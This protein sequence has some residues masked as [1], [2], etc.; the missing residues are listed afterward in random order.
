MTK[1]PMQLVSYYQKV[2]SSLEPDSE[3]A[4]MAHYV[5]SQA[6]LAASDYGNAETALR[7]T[8]AFYPDK[9]ILK[10][11]LGVIY[12]KSGRYD[13][14]VKLLQETNR[15]ERNNGYANFYLAVALEKTGKLQEASDLYEE[16]LVM[17]P[18]YT[19]LYYQLANVRASMGKQG[20]GFY[21]YGYY[22]WYE[23]DLNS[24]KYHYSK[25]VSLLPQESQMKVD[26]ENMLK[27]IAQFEKEQ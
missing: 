14:A 27:K 19:K 9:P 4:A 8:M 21:Y 15:A 17:M 16:L 6:F 22:Y 23:G 18:D 1:E 20:E 25:A 7:K 12:L 24:A 10:A 11:D 2:L 13:E 26:A 3:T 5:L